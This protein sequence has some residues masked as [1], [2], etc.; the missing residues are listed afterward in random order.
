MAGVGYERLGFRRPSI[1]MLT[2]RQDNGTTNPVMLGDPS[3]TRVVDG[4]SS[5]A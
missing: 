4:W 5:A 3:G 1:S 2:V